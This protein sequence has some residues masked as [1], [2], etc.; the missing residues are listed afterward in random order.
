VQNLFQKKSI[1]LVVR[2]PRRIFDECLR[3][4]TFKRR[5][6]QEDSTQVSC[7]EEYFIEYN[8][9]IGIRAQKPF[10]PLRT[11]KMGQMIGPQEVNIFLLMKQIP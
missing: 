1:L 7:T 9:S 3:I 4:V 6:T 2:G 5:R 10:M 11:A 8:P